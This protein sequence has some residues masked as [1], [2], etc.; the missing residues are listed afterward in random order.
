MSGVLGLAAVMAIGVMLH[1]W[2]TQPVT[3]ALHRR[4]DGEYTMR[5]RRE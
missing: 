5:A 1:R 2:S 3:D 4:E